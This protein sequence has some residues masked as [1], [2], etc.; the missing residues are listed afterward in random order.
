MAWYHTLLSDA[1]FWMASQPFKAAK[2]GLVSP[3]P[4]GVKDLEAALRTHPH[5]RFVPD[6]GEAKAKPKAKAKAKA[7]SAEKKPAK[8]KKG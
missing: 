2:D 8:K 7:K 6:E 3:D 1:E 4:S 5:F